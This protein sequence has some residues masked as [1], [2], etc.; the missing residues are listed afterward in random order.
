MFTGC[1]IYTRLSHGTCCHLGAGYILESDPEKSTVISIL[2]YSFL[3]I[4]SQPILLPC[5]Q[6]NLFFWVKKTLNFLSVVMHESNPCTQ[7]VN[8]HQQ[9]LE[10]ILNK[11]RINC[12]LLWSKD[13]LNL[14]RCIFWN[15]CCKLLVIGP[16]LLG[17]SGQASVIIHRPLCF[18]YFAPPLPAFTSSSPPG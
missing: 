3:G 12:N 7:N 18:P 5:R 11:Y 13:F 16:T 10:V 15:S 8:L 17:E 1:R 4:C 14:L 6:S 2:F 9:T